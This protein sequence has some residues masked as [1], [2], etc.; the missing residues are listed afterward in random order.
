VKNLTQNVEGHVIRYGV[1]VFWLLFWLFN[2]IDK[3]VAQP[4]FLWA[5]KDRLAQ[6]RDYFSSIGLESPGVALTFFIFVLL[7]EI[8]A[9]VLLTVALLQLVHE[10][11]VKARAWFFWGTFVGL[12]IFSF[13]TIG[14]QVFGDR[15]ELLEHTIY[16][17]SLIVSWG[18]YN[19]FPK[20]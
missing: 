10:E 3:F 12:V 18:A 19:Y 20:K 8:L 2:V 16:W 1:L 17:V 4:V 13:F 14:D 5:G 7:L 15:K 6:F 9:L 11:N